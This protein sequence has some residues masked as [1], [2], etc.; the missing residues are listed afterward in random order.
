MICIISPTYKQASNFAH[1]QN[2]DQTEWFYLSDAEDVKW[3][4]N[5]HVLVVGEFPSERLGW[6][7]KVYS[8]ARYRGKV[9]R[10]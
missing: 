1:T 2:L 4:S 8:I 5:F 10:V 3:R 7:E 6:F 9:N